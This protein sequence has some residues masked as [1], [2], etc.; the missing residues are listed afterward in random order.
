MEKSPIFFKQLS[1]EQLTLAKSSFR[2]T[3]AEFGSITPT[4]TLSTRTGNK[5]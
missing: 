1:S 3:I 2:T 5:I 4:P